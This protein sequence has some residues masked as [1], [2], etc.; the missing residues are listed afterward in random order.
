[1]NE[2]IGLMMHSSQDFTV[3]FQQHEKNSLQVQPNSESMLSTDLK[4][5]YS[6]DFSLVLHSAQAYSFAYMHVLWT[7]LSYN[8]VSYQPVP[9]KLSSSLN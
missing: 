2:C 9:L 3:E 6:S 4:Q 7:C 8:F 1:M 5:N